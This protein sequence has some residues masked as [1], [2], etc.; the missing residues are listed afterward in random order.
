M[1]PLQVHRQQPNISNFL[2]IQTLMT[3]LQVQ[4]LISHQCSYSHMQHRITSIYITYLC[5]S[6]SATKVK[7]AT[8]KKKLSKQLKAL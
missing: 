6:I 1:T 5:I 2:V 4:E 8:V 7:Q 3:Q